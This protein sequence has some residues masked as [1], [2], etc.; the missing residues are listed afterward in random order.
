MCSIGDR[1]NF[2][3]NNTKTDRLNF[4]FYSLIFLKNGGS[5]Q[6]VCI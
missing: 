6:E 5:G 4:Y 1:D 3:E 2:W